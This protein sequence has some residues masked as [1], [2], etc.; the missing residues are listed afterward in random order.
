MFNVE[1]IYGLIR[2]S[3]ATGMIPLEATL[4]VPLPDLRDGKLVFC[5][6]AYMEKH[7]RSTGRTEIYR[8]FAAILVDPASRSVVEVRSVG[9]PSGPASVAE[10]IGV[11]AEP[12]EDS[13]SGNTAAEEP[14]LYPTL[15]EVSEWIDQKGLSEAQ[16]GKVRHLAELL[17]ETLT[18][19]L[20]PYLEELCPSFFALLEEAD[21]KP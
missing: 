5:S 20:R 7:D 21:R 6:L 9:S 12:P 3:P 14:S 2:T 1:S 13:G 10:P 15:S 16:R 4:S 8:P 18:S 19:G 11:M 17:H